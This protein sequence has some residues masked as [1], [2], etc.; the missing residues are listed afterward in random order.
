MTNSEFEFE[1]DQAKDHVERFGFDSSAI[2]RVVLENKELGLAL[3]QIPLT[4]LN[5]WLDQTPEINWEGVPSMIGY[6]WEKNPKGIVSIVAI[7]E[8]TLAA[9]HEDRVV[10]YQYAGP[11]LPPK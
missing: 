2:V 5:N 10:G 1:T 7:N 3:V 9:I 4:I 6:Y 8:E 11:L